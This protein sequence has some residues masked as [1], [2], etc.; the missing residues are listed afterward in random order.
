M[1]RIFL[2]MAA[3]V[4]LISTSCNQAKLKQL[5]Q[6]NESLKWESNLK[7]SNMQL[8]VNTMVGIQTN[9]NTI[10]SQEKE[11]SQTIATNEEVGQDLETQINSDINN[12]Y[13]LLIANKE[14]VQKLQNALSKASRNNAAA[15]A[16]ANK[17]IESLQSQIAQQNEQIAQ[18]QQLLQEKDIKI[19]YLDNAIIKLS[20]SV[21]S[22]ANVNQQTTDKLQATTEDLET[23]YYIVATK[24]ELKD[25][26]IITSDG[27]F[28]KKI[29]AGNYDA[30]IFT[31]VN[32][33]SV[34]EIEIL[35]SKAKVLTNH[36]ESSYSIEENGDALRLV[37]KDRE[38]FWQVSKYLVIQSK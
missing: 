21:D 1:K 27:L 31:K 2:V 13:K 36:P 18:L 38:A 29:M 5:E 8:L 17:L 6:E 19:A 26:G 35:S 3:I 9:L 25:K 11:L 23:A 14:K 33:K 16:S 7:D 32:V 10:K 30:S 20:T 12:I 4:A 28:S 37:I 22:L 24:S 34:D 15:Q